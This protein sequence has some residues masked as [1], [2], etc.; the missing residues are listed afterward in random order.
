MTIQASAGHDEDIHENPEIFDLFRPAKTH[1]SFASGPHFCQ[2]T[3]IARLML[4]QIM[5]PL[6]FERFPNMQ[7]VNPE[8]VVW[9]GFAFRGPLTLPVRLA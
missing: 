5:L 8:E 9:S 7:L 1:Q 6:L 3:H 2:G 4:A